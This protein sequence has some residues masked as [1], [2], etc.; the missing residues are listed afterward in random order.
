M[1]GNADRARRAAVALLV[2]YALGG[3]VATGAAAEAWQP[4]G[5]IDGIAMT[6]RPTGTGFDAYR[7]TVEVCTG[8]STLERFVTDASSFGEWIPYTVEA[9]QIESGDGA[10][11]YY[12]RTDAPW[13]A[14]DRDMVYRLDSRRS[15]EALVIA[16]TGVPD[17]LPPQEGAVRMAGAEGEWRLRPRGDRLEVTFSLAVNP[18]NAPARFSNRRLA[19]TVAGTLN[20]LTERFPC[21]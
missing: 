15:D 14:R 13:P 2:L 5:T 21:G 20:N 8:A 3:A 19:A 12:V 6:A 11:R 1:I 7:A 17:Y 9:R 4:A 16:V 10:V 18:G